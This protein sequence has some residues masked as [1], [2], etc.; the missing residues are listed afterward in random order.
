MTCLFNRRLC[1]VNSGLIS[2][3]IEFRLGFE[4][5][6]TTDS[7][8]ELG[9]SARQRKGVVCETL[10]SVQDGWHLYPYFIT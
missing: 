8:V 3:R 6:Q 7:L 5:T 2:R 10:A 1:V 9:N 4:S